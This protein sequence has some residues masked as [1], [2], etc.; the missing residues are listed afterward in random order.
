MTIPTS[1]TIVVFLT[2]QTNCF[3]VKILADN[4]LDAVV[5]YLSILSLYMFR[6]S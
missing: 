6:A 5:V 2:E 3:I 4:Q 1:F